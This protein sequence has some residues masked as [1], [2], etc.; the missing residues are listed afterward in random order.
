MDDAGL[1][2]A[3]RRAV[4]ALRRRGARVALA[5][6]CTAGLVAASLATVEGASDVLWGGVV[7]YG[8]DAKATLAGLGDDWLARHG[9]VS[10]ATTE[11]LAGHILEASG[12]AVAVAITGWAGPTG[13]TAADPVG[14][15]YVSVSG[16]EGTVDTRRRVLGG[17]RNAVR[18]GAARLALEGLVVWAGEGER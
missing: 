10:A 7:V 6:S 1:A 14:T 15:V 9:T 12:T 18:R 17:D 13:G 11:A 5:E 4:G 8:A 3:A 16:R 2:A